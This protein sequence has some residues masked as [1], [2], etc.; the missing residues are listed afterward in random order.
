M[1]HPLSVNLIKTLHS[2]YTP[3]QISNYNLLSLLCWL[4]VKSSLTLL[5]E[6]VTALKGCVKTILILKN[7]YQK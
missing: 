6:K 3:I 7:V 2:F 5:N 1:L 4:R